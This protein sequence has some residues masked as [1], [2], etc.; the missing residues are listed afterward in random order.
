[1]AKCIILGCSFS[2]GDKGTLFSFPKDEFVRD[3]WAH[4]VRLYNSSW[5]FQ[6]T[7]RI[8]SQ[9]FVQCDFSNWSQFHMGFAQKLVLVKGAVPTVNGFASG[10]SDS[11]NSSLLLTDDDRCVKKRKLNA[12]TQC[13]FYTER[14][15]ERKSKASQTD[16][17]KRAV[18]EY[19]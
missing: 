10:S 14:L 3:K 19:N 16:C 7:D 4:F 9:H 5:V 2:L 18:G 15:L 6:T 17:N 11:L 12:E 1:M 13:D 8:C